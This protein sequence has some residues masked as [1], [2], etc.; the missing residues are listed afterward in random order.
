VRGENEEMKIAYVYDV[1]HPY[2]KGGAEKRIW[3][4]SKRLV[5]KKH[6][7]YLFGMKYW[8]GG[9]VI[10][11]DGV[12][13]HGVCEPNELYVEGRRS[14][15]EA[16]YFARKLLFPLMK[17]DFD[18]I[19]CHAFPYFPCFS[20][21]I[22]SSLKRTPLVITWHEI[23]NDYWYDYLGKK[24]IFGKVVEKMTTHL[25]DKMIAV[26]ERT[27][28]DLG[29]IGV[30]KEIKVIPNG[31]DFVKI[32]MIEA[33]NEETD[34]V[35]AGRLIREKNVDVLIEAVNIIKKEVP[36]V[37]CMIIGDGPEKR[38]LEKMVYDLGLEAN[39]EFTG[40]LADH[41]DVI[42]YIKS[43]KVFVLPSIREGFGIV[44]LEAN[45]CGLPVITVNHKMNAACDFINNN[46]NGFICE[47]SEEEI[48][49]KIFI[50]LD[51]REDMKRKC[52]ENARGYDWD[53][54][55]NLTESFYLDTTQL[56]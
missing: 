37:K 52:V 38:R 53:N 39:I 25:T 22:C 26:S 6:E 14:I 18:V 5:K 30:R 28:R 12:Y 24:G 56:R 35:F 47:L 43:S 50:A 45:A 10:I 23:W 48:T 3:E 9:D 41:N 40:F 7:V 2:V 20:A 51:R 42:S 15:K 36:D 4:I 29:M 54:A 55:V 32:G 11:K 21:K 27:K 8:N 17:E 19:D 1:I 33:S 31:I 49:E 13:L 46:G 44:A 16:I 34:V